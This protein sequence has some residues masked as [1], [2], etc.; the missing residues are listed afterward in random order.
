ML[1]L[2]G[3][4]SL[5]ARSLS[6]QRAGVEVAGQNLANVNNT[7]YARQ[8][9]SIATSPTIATIVGPQG[10]GA[11]AIAI[12]QMRSAIL[13]NQIQIEGSNRGSLTAQQ[14]A[15]QYTQAA[16]GAQVDRTTS[17]AEGAAAASGVGSGHSLSDSLGELFNA[18]QSLSSN[19]TSMA[20][21]QTLLMKASSV[22]LQ[23]NQLDARLAEL[24]S[25]LNATLQSDVAA[26]NQ[27]LTDIA[28][29]NEMITLAETSS[30]GFANDLR[31]TRQARLEELAKYVKLDITNGTGSALNIS[32]GGVL[33]VADN[34]VADTL[35]T[36]T[37]PGGQLL[38]NT[39]NTSLPVTITGGSIH[40]TIEAR[41]GAVTTLR[42]NINLL[43]TTLIT[44][45]S[46]THSAGISLYNTGGLTFFNGTNA[47]NIAVEPLLL[48]D[49]ANVHAAGVTNAPGDNRI[50]LEL[51]QYAQRLMPTL[52]NQTFSQ[53][54]SQTVAGFGQ[55]LSTVNNQLGDQQAVEN[56]LLRQRDS[57][58]GVS[59]DE[60]MT[61]LTRFQKAF[62]ASAR[63]ITTVDE[64]LET[65][66][67]MK[68]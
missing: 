46:G 65:V 28:K 26:T 13:D 9:V 10:T 39:T 59:L 30:G 35:Q 44:Y 67:T 12:T 22:A 38:V 41:D 6:T 64:M 48:D 23:F 20:E 8:R 63:L 16:L 47:S 14:L 36:F 5:G 56:M 17:S 40:G 45:L 11:D 54:Y 58:G 62:A 43:A 32:I 37:G 66:V 7:A 33:M 50:A 18:F 15:L 60:E 51:A 68:R 3:T 52:N 2:F 42:D 57:I 1:G 24:T 29:L 4:L 34:Q 55:A 25:S 49:P 61:D 27:L 21:R 19:P 31:D 53:F